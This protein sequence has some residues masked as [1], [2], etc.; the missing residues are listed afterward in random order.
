MSVCL[1]I[2]TSKGA[3]ECF[4]C[5]WKAQAAVGPNTYKPQAV[6]DR[7]IGEHL[8]L[9]HDR[10]MVTEVRSSRNWNG[11]SLVATRYFG[12]PPSWLEQQI[13]ERRPTGPVRH[14]KAEKAIW[15]G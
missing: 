15:R 13:E 10:F 11:E 14:T 4:W 7:L 9:E 6:V 1:A 3:V 5:G 8:L 2:A 12:N